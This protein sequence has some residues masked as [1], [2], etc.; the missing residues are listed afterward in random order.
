MYVHTHTHALCP[1]CKSILRISS[2]TLLWISTIP[3]SPS[4]LNS[5]PGFQT[6]NVFYRKLATTS[7]SRLKFMSFFLSEI[8]LLQAKLKVNDPWSTTLGGCR[9]PFNCA[10]LPT[11]TISRYY[12]PIIL[13]AISLGYFTHINCISDNPHIREWVAVNLSSIHLGTNHLS[14]SQRGRQE[15]GEVGRGGGARAAPC[16]RFPSCQAYV[17]PLTAKS[18]GLF[19]SHTPGKVR[20]VWCLRVNMLVQMVTAVPSH[21]HLSGVAAVCGRQAVQQCPTFPA[22]ILTSTDWSTAWQKP[23]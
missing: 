13:I 19:S 11:V 1:L 5:I 22:Y 9:N 15:T 2:A 7:S 21:I 12:L 10:L 23:H 20:R 14:Q 18:Q 3:F 17:H 4:F 8:S 6:N 16:C